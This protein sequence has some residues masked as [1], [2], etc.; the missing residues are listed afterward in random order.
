[1]AYKSGEEIYLRYVCLLSLRVL[2]ELSEIS[3]DSSRSNLDKKDLT[4]KQPQQLTLSLGI[5]HR[6]SQ[7]CHCPSRGA[8]QSSPS[9]PPS[10]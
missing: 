5:P 9:R 2:H 4:K 1:M 7:P 6:P 8:S 3:T 10:V